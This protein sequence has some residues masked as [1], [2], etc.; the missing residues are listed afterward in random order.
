[1]YRWK[2]K[3]KT[4]RAQETSRWSGSNQFRGKEKGEQ[5]VALQSDGTANERRGKRR[6]NAEKCHEIT[7]K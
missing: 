1:M 5:L 7:R 3:K 2:K 6:K 4:T